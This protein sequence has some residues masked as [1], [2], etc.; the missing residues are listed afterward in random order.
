MLRQLM[1]QWALPALLVA[2]L[3]GG[4]AARVEASDVRDNAGM[5]SKEAV[6]KAQAALDRIESQHKVPVLIETIPNLD[7]KPVD[8]VAKA[9]FLE[10]NHKMLYVLIAKDERKISVREPQSLA[11]RIGQ[12]DRAQ[13]RQAFIDQFKNKDFDAGLTRAVATIDEIASSKKA[14]SGPV[15]PVARGG[16]APPAVPAQRSSLG[17]WLM[18]GLGIF[19]VLMVFRLLGR[20]MNG[21]NRGYA[22]G[23]GAAPGAPAGYGPGYGGGGYGGGGGGGMF[24][25]MMAGLG[26]ALAGNWLYNQF[27]GSH[28]HPTDTAG[29]GGG[30]YSSGQDAAGYDAGPS[31]GVGE[32]TGWADSG[33]DAGGGGDW[34][35]G[36]GDWGGGGGGDVGGGDW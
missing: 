26:G 3:V 8:D 21:G 10:S 30:G 6:S 25:T 29:M 16:A 19:A 1:M 28:S 34:G 4:S 17:T 13:I 22:P 24:G 20:M 18:I 35:G 14:T 31:E 27:S 36:G 5:F 11:N 12:A 15:L 9:R 2:G 23:P 32:S 33:G 7:G